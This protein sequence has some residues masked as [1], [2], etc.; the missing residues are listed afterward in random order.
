M[1][2]IY[3]KITPAIERGAKYFPVIV[4]TGPRQSGKS[5]LCRRIFKDYEQY[6]LEDVGLRENIHNDPKAFINNCGEYV[7]I[8]EAQHL[9][10]L[11]SYIQNA[12]DEKPERRFVL[13]GSSNFALMEK[14]T[15]SL[16]G[17]AILFTL[18][19]LAMDE[20]SKSYIDL[21]SQELIYNGFYPSV[22]TG[23][24]PADLF[25]P[26]YYS[27]YVERDLRAL[28]NISD[29]SQFQTFIRLVAGRVGSEFNASQIGVETGISAPTVKAW[30]STLQASYIAFLL[31]PYYAN[32]NK[33]L[34]KTPKIYFYD[35]GLL[36]YL[37]DIENY[38]QLVTHPLKG[39]VF[40]NLAVIELLKQRFNQGKASNLY[41][42]RENSGREADILQTEGDKINIYEVKA[43]Q[44]WNKAFV[45]N[46]NYLKELFG[47]KI[48]QT[49]VIYDGN[50]I[51]PST[52]NIRDLTKRF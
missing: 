8:D 12:V 2:Y 18:L 39:A 5:T 24:R 43:S 13:T 32:V 48:N 7:L 11:F 1:E 38:N 44:T 3:R 33:R 14:I 30:M 25:Y 35:T 52:I 21:S 47:D 4:V 27:T 6:N 10:E 31:Q 50:P 16:A 28:K 29:L 46:L 26:S 20:L 23:M 40:E 15:Q 19:P 36:S 51:P 49:A 42:Y 34:T 22:V 17:R 41:Y 45:K 37:L 9:P